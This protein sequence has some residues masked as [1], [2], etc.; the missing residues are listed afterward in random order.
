MIHVTVTASVRLKQWISYRS[1]GMTH[2]FT[3]AD[4]ERQTNAFTNFFNPEN[5][6]GNFI[7]YYYYIIIIIIIIYECKLL[8][9]KVVGNSKVT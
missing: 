9:L 2:Q 8:R 6:C 4:I 7:Y 5:V 3:L 1:A